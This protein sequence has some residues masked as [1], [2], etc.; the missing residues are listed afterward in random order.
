MKNSLCILSFLI[1]SIAAS[2]QSNEPE[3]NTDKTIR[4][5][6]QI[7]INATEFIKQFVVLNNATV[8]TVSPYDFNAK[9]F[10]GWNRFPS[11]LIGPRIGFG[12]RSNHQY[13]NTEQQNNERSTDTKSRA[14]RV[15]IM[16]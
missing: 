1:C 11:L 5:K 13:S 6:G 15:Y 3:T 16:A 4:F 10:I 14:A 9:G 7:G 12:Y 2:A 8:T